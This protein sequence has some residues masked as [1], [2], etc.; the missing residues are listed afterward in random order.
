MRILVTGAAGFIGSTLVDHLLA[1]GHKVVAVDD[2]SSGRLQNLSAAGA[3]AGFRFVQADIA[4]PGTAELVAESAPEAICHL[5]AQVS[6]RASVHDP[7][8][9]AVQNVVGTVRVLEAARLAGVRRVVFTSSGGSVYGSPRDLPV[10]EETPTDPLSPYATSKAAGELYARTFHR[11][12]GLETCSLA[13]ANV[14]GP[15]QDPHGEAGVVAIF[16]GA[17][18]RGE[19]TRVYGDGRQT[20][21]YVYVGDVVA[22]FS[23]AV[24]PGAPGGDG[25]RYNIGTGVQTA[26][27][28]LHRLVAAATGAPDDPEFAPPRLGD[29]KAIAV[30]PGRAERELGWRPEVGLAEGIARTVE[31]FRA[32]V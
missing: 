26:D 18:L 24:V 3:D 16:S 2:L 8:Q 21:D 4:A 6:V 1:A 31:W 7:V 22:A 27:R 30:D 11:L 17:M 29:L 9:D 28:E 10:S 13:L 12:H 19:S 25:R 5:A 20:R 23:R 14:Y 32:R 15:R